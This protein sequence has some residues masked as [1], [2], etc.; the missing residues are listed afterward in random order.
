MNIQRKW[1]LPEYRKKGFPDK[2][3][4]RYALGDAKKKKR[5]KET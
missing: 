2:T 1:R 3:L 5:G 4:V